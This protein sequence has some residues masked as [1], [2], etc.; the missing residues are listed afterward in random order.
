M[1]VPAVKTTIE[2][3]EG[4]GNSAK[5]LFE[6]PAINWDF[7]YADEE[8]ID[9]NRVLIYIGIKGFC[10]YQIACREGGNPHYAY[11]EFPGGWSSRVSVFNAA[12]NET[13]VEASSGHGISFD[14]ALVL[15]KE[16]HPDVWVH[17]WS[18]H[19]YLDGDLVES[20][21]NIVPCDFTKGFFPA[22]YQDSCIT[23][24]NTASPTFIT[25]AT[26]ALY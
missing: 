24:L 5:F 8:D 16:N 12:F 11:G 22:R 20:S 10:R 21:Y 3:Y 4:Y 15:I 1:D 23:L 13:Y 17:V 25:D 14:R 7:Y 6:F 18:H 19:E 26:N 9:E 2:W